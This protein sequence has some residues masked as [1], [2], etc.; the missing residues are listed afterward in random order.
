MTGKER[1]VGRHH[2]FPIKRRGPSREPKHRILV[3]CEGEKT[4]P[5]YFRD[6]QHHVRNPR[7]HVQPHGPAGVPK[8]VVE[9]AIQK[10]REAETQAKWERDDNLLW[11]EVWAVFDVDE[12]PGLAEA[13]Q[14][15]NANRIDLA[16]SNPCFELWALLH[17]QDQNAHI[18]RQKVRE[19]LQG[20]LVDYD[21]VLD[22]RKLRDGYAEAV[23]RAQALDTA[24]THHDRPGRNP[25]T[26]VYQLTEV[27]RTK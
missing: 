14:L 8:T 27:I 9:V 19:A 24:A 15:A 11:D 25:T 20:H 12:H 3:V 4:E 7:V 13:R 5:Q 2:D 6:L 21:K 22:F 1:A 16:I 23:R 10:R 17:F 18:E 26:G